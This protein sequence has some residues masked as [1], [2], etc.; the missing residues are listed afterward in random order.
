M[1]GGHLHLQPAGMAEGVR[2]HLNLTSGAPSHEAGPL[3]PDHSAGP[4][5]C[6]ALRPGAARAAA[7]HHQTPVGVP[8]HNNRVPCAEESDRHGPRRGRR[9][10][11]S[12]VG[13]G[14]WGARGGPGRGPGVQMPRLHLR[15]MPPGAHGH[16]RQRVPF[17]MAACPGLNE[18]QSHDPHEPFCQTFARFRLFKRH[19]TQYRRPCH[20]GRRDGP[21]DDPLADDGVWWVPEQKPGYPRL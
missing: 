12:A 8:L 6:V 18:G 19:R 1:E 13:V 14:L 17:L 7:V 3:K 10:R 16:G 11:H 9:V 20:G 4:S 5:V 2:A 21:A 15:D